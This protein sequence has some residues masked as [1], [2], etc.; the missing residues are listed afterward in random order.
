MAP[1]ALLGN[2]NFHT[3]DGSATPAILSCHGNRMA[4]APPR[5][6]EVLERA[7]RVYIRHRLTID[8][9]RRTRLGAPA[10][11]HYVTMQLGGADFQHHLL[12]LALCRECKL[13]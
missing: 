4:A 2:Y 9:Q 5:F 7:V 13:E 8:D 1:V 11:L 3:L 12:A 6:R 10:D